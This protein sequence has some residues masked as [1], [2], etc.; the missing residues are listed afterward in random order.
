VSASRLGD[1]G[2]ASATLGEGS[3]TRARRRS[4]HSDVLGYQDVETK[5]PMRC[6]IRARLAGSRAG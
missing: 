3:R 2:E 4:L 5:T 6:D 1:V